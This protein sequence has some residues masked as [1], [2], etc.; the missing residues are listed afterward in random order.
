MFEYDDDFV[1]KIV[2]FYY[3]KYIFI[4]SQVFHFYFWLLP[5]LLGWCAVHRRIHCLMQ[6][7]IPATNTVPMDVLPL[8]WIR[9]SIPMQKRKFHTW[10]D[11]PIKTWDITSRAVKMHVTH[12]T[13][14]KGVF[15]AVQFKFRV[16]FEFAMISWYI[17]NFAMIRRY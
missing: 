10:S 9:C 5:T 1:V 8:F 7:T 15:C 13:I 4:A 14:S 16:P 2:Y 3:I 17:L 11:A 12:G 6:N